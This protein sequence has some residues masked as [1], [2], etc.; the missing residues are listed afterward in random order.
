MNDQLNG[1]MCTH[2]KKNQLSH[3]MELSYIQVTGS[4]KAHPFYLACAD[5]ACSYIL[6]SQ[7]SL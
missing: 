2:G 1:L 7:E 4:P 6:C 3:A 5:V